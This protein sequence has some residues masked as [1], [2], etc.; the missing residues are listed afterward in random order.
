MRMG[1]VLVSLLLLATAAAEE[2]Q[3][4]VAEDDAGDVQLRTQ[5]G[6]VSQPAPSGYY[7]NVDVTAVGVWAEDDS[8]VTFYIEVDDLTEDSQ[9]P[10]PVSDPDYTLYFRYGEQGYRVVV[11]TVLDNAFNGVF[12]R[13]PGAFARLER[14]V[15]EDRYSGFAQ[16]EAELDYSEDRV[17][18]MVP[19]DA[20]LDHNQAP[21][22]RN[23]TLRD[24]FVE[25]RSM[26]W[27]GFPF[28]FGGED[29]SQIGIP[30]AL[31]R[32]PDDGDDDGSY[33]VTTGSVQQKGK[34][35]AVSDD[36]IRWT[37][38]EATTLT[39]PVRV[40]NIGDAKV[41]LKLSLADTDDSW[42]VAHTDSL[43]VPAHRSVNTTILVTIP[44]LHQH[45]VTDLFRAVFASDDGVH[46]ATALLGIH[47]PTVPQPAGHHDTLWLHSVRN[48]VPAPFDA[49]FSSVHGWF[50]ASED[51]PDDEGVGIP[52]DFSTFPGFFGAQ[53]GEAQW[54][55][56]LEP[57]LRMG[58]DFDASR[59]GTATLA[60]V[61]PA[62]AVDPYVEVELLHQGQGNGGRGG[63]GT[64][65]LAAGVSPTMSGSQSGDVEFELE[66][67]TPAG[68]DV[69]PYDAEANLVLRIS[70]RGTLLVGGGFANPEAATPLLAAG[71]SILQLPLEE[72]HDPTNLAFQTDANVTIVVGQTGQE[73]FVNAG[74]TVVYTFQLDYSGDAAAAF[75]VTISGKNVAWGT[76]IGDATFD[77]EAGTQRILGLAV[78]APKDA[79]DGEQADITLTLTQS[80]NAAIQAGVRTL[81]TVTSSEDIPDETDMQK[82]LAG[83]LSKHKDASALAVLWLAIGLLALARR[84]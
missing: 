24:I 64:Q 79:R 15:G 46:G 34:I 69:V 3:R 22:A 41:S 5:D 11:T 82:E 21:L 73:R 84:R 50:S 37:N 19:R 30:E 66:L 78:A 51:T 36:P 9:A 32:A 25:S 40:S 13:E 27:F 56:R 60:F 17:L 83:T 58:L 42:Q 1:V 31:D 47:W 68:V 39:F 43:S 70:L 71:G 18:A 2:V 48:P 12:E 26:G 10:T 52:A 80:K 61:L 53:E 49:A 45:G 28:F 38:G 20:I 33:I 29:G 76:I 4:Q 72:Y 67:Q 23:A 7:D 75:D 55:L 57:T 44:F 14:Q 65:V 63:Q 35:F 77:L 16:A 81:T 8:T 54:F 59:M 74:R 62:P 6:A